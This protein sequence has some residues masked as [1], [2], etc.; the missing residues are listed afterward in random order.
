MNGKRRLQITTHVRSAS[1]TACAMAAVLVMLS[2]CAEDKVVEKPKTPVR[3]T[4]VSLGGGASG[5][6]YSA[7]VT[8][9]TQV[10]LAFK[11]GGY[12][13]AITQRKGADG[14]VRP[15]EAGDVVSSGEVLAK[16][17]EGEYF[18]RVAQATAQVAQA[19]AASEKSRLDFER[20]S[21]LFASNSM[22]KAQFDAAKASDDAN[23]AALNSAEAA[24]S[25]AQIALHDCTLRSPITG[26]VIQR[27]VEVG[28]LVGSGTQAFVVADTRV[29]KVVFGV[30]DTMI[31]RIR[32]GDLQSITTLTV[33]GEIRG[34]VTSISPSADPK[35]RVFSV[36]VS[37]ANADN[38][39]KPG[40]IATLALGIDKAMR[41]AATVVVP[42]SAVIRSSKNGGAFAVFVVTP[43]SG[44]AAGSTVA[45]EREVKVGPTMG[46]SIAVTQGL[47]PG[48]NVVSAGATEIRDGEQVRVL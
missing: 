41:E 16:V 25:Q 10:N 9:N 21:N 1:L 33:P 36:E 37:I 27:D 31:Q 3:V 26:W 11:S 28:S 44:T 34:R 18:D 20:A 47:Q 17:R 22:T 23:S 48:E 14:R 45:H 40:M 30:P 39:L 19:R 13:E 42:L 46:N 7:N 12:V 29:V 32:L 6:R 4:P 8:A 2:G 43:E 24:A 15:L 35:S 5:I 38:R